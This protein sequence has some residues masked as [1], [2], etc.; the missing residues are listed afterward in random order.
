MTQLYTGLELGEAKK[1]YK[2]MIKVMILVS[3]A[4]LLLFAGIFVLRQL[5]EYGDSDFLHKFFATLVSI[6]YGCFMLFYIQLPLRRCRGFLKLYTVLS[7][8]IK[9]TSEAV[10]LGMDVELS[11]KYGVDFHELL[12][13]EG[14]NHKGREIISRALVDDEVDISEIEIGDKVKF[15]SCGNVITAYEVTQK[16]AV[17]GDQIDVMMKRLAEHVGMDNVIIVDAPKRKRRRKR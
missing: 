15:E 11:E 1:Q 17:D 8:S 3:V 7:T 14:V 16:E 4:W 10:F 12:F 9:K 13:F 6:V 5:R 2:K